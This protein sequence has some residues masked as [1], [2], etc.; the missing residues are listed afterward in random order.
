MTQEGSSYE[1][2]KETSDWLQKRIKI[3]PTIGVICGSG[4]SN[5]GE[6]VKYSKAIPYSEIPNFPQSTVKG[7]KS[8]ILFGKISGKEVM[9]LQGRFH[10]YEGYPGWMVTFPI[11]VMKLMGVETLI[12]TNATGGVNEKYHVGDIMIQVDYLSIPTF[13]ALNPLT[14]PND[15]KFGPRFVSMNGAYTPELIELCEKV[16]KE[17]KYSDFLWK[18]VYGMTSGPTYETPSETKMLRMVGVDVV[19][20]STIPEVIAAR[21]CGLKIFG[22]SLVTNVINTSWQT[23][24]ET[25]HKEVVDMGEKYAERVKKLV[26]KM[27]EN[28][29]GGESKTP[30]ASNKK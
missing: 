4:L 24:I 11:R 5:I 23:V 13:T 29:D 25:S 21:H 3:K 1:K 20:M 10:P 27:I 14:G 7:H 9:L 18:G 15:E 8:Q 17:M 12:V 6:S 22:L 28:M 19:G 16:G 2:I 30:K 26:I